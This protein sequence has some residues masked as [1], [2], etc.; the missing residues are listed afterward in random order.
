MELLAHNAGFK[1]I[2][3]FSYP[4]PPTRKLT[5][6]LENFIKI[7]RIAGI[8]QL[9]K[10]ELGNTMYLTLQKKQLIN[11]TSLKKNQRYPKHIYL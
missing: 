3:A 10:K 8:T 4:L 11:P 1:T 9:T 6:I 2:E 5:I 7:L